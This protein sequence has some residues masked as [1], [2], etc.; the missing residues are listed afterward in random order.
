MDIVR[1][2]GS[3]AAKKLRLK[4]SWRV[5]SVM[6]RVWV[7][8]FDA[9]FVHLLRNKH[10]TLEVIHK[11]VITLRFMQFLGQP[12]GGGGGEARDNINEMFHHKYDTVYVYTID[13]RQ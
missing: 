2:N 1:N 12:F 3:A 13:Y 11:C 9:H 7:L 8:W 6:V 5:D 10:N 4:K